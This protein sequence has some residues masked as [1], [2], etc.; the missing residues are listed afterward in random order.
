[1]RSLVEHEK[2]YN[3]MEAVKRRTTLRNS[4]ETIFGTTVSLPNI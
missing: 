3:L 4:A 2:K 1:M